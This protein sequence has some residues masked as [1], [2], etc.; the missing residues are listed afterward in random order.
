[1]Q[2]G[3]P[4]D[5]GAHGGCG[6]DGPGQWVARASCHHRRPSPYSPYVT[7]SASGYPGLVGSLGIGPGPVPHPAWLCS[8]PVLRAPIVGADKNSHCTLW[9]Y[10]E[11]RHGKFCRN[12][13]QTLPLTALEYH[14][15]L[16]LGNRVGRHV[17]GVSDARPTRPSATVIAEKPT[18]RL[19]KRGYCDHRSARRHGEAQ[20]SPRRVH[21][22]R[23]SACMTLH[24]GP[25]KDGQ[26]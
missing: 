3:H 11:I 21:P 1:M 12:E 24:R 10:R 7:S 17:P 22:A 18:L 25:G 20:H 9:T 4:V 26:G 16:V 5:L 6:C 15:R 14:R 13:G 23:H 2:R 19:R 8:A